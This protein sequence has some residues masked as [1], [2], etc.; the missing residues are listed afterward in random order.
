MSPPAAP[1]HFDELR[2]GVSAPAPVAG[3]GPVLEVDA[4]ALP[5]PAWSRFFE[6]LG[7]DGF[8][9]LNRR[10]TNLER[11]VRDNGVTYNVYAE[12]D[13]PQRPWSLDLF[14]LIVTPESW[15]HIETGVLQR[16]RLLDSVMA[17][18]Y[19]PQTLLARN[20]LPPALVHGH[21]GY[22]RPMHGIKP[23]GDTHLH[24]A[25]F[26]LARGPDGRWWVVSQRT[27][28]P[29][30][31]G[32]LLENRLIASRLFPEAFRG[33][34]VQRLAATY[35]ALIDGIKQ[36]C[37]TQSDPRIVLLTPGPY[38]ETYFEHAY[39]ARYLG[40]TLVEGSDLTVRDQ[41]L[42]LKT[43]KGL[44][45]VHGLLKR[46]DDEFL[47]PLELR[48]DSRLGVPGL[49]QVLRTGNVLVANAPGSAFLESTA[50]LGFLPALSRHLLGQELQL[51]SLAT[52]WCGERAATEAVLPELAGCVI[53]PTHATPGTGAVLGKSLT[54]RELDEWAGRIVRQGDEYTVQAY[55][56]LSQM[57]TWKDSRGAASTSSGRDN[58]I[59]PRSAMLR[60]FAVSDGPQ[61][62][63][64]LPGGLTRIA[65]AGLDIA[66]MQRGG[67]SADT[68]V[69]TQGE[70]DATSLLQHDQPAATVSHR[71]RNS[72][73]SRAAEN[74][75]WLGR[76]TERTENTT[77][78]ARLTLES[79]NGEDQHSQPL[80]AWLGELAV[81]H[82]L[83][84]PAVPPPTQGR[85]VFQ[86]SLIS[87][88]H[89]P[90]QTSVGHNLSGLLS[91][92][93]AV[94]ERLS[95]EQWKV[96]VQ[97]EKQF[98][99]ECCGAGRDGDYSS[100]DALRAL[101]NLSGHTAAMTGAQTDRMTRDDGWRL[102]SSGRHLE[103]LGFLSSA[104]AHA[105]DT[106]GVFD[107]GGF[108]A[109]ISLFDS[110]I[111]FH[112]Q[113]QQR[114]DIPALL[115]LLILDRDNP[116]SLGWVAQTLRGRLAKLAGSAPG[117]VP[118]I[119]L[120][121]PD[122]ESWSLEEICE[123][124]ADGHYGPL[125]ALLAHCGQ[126]VYKLSDDLGARYFTHSGE[127]RHS[128]GA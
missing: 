39:L 7:H 72:T 81:A 23:P 103:R 73:T 46:L 87:A 123:R 119:A 35:R 102:L 105:F 57:P 92:A 11:R 117:K 38:N 28:A 4:H 76:Y 18:V 31:L 25:A 61:S 48:S 64:V 14:P 104:L 19:G 100:V 30:G 5:T 118:E 2:G 124:D 108:G 10:T 78:L 94:R 122:P 69:M 109:L 82:A 62:W 8:L 84:L 50:I 65:G 6:R 58:R 43:L 36:M 88:L 111:T 89:D 120:T 96:I 60:V 12:S 55:L 77:R 51:P 37:P 17:D 56:P 99:Q 26:D 74:L 110:T 115:D 40:L 107:E 98:V 22:L 106:G 32:Y 121:V 113:Y 3:T 63:R 52:W 126:A 86:R 53:K 67:S 128:V 127:A 91:A 125:L 15:Q 80:L 1:G 44:E 9:D 29:S 13:G 79:L 66:S 95:L 49:L 114:H 20:L 68:W 85:R 41:R 16:V 70:V 83:V 47:D 21:P 116:R 24:I 90:E 59:V 34:R 54:R 101:E 71:S 93:S 75:F 33:L 97:A 27:Q 112:A 42:Y 45:P